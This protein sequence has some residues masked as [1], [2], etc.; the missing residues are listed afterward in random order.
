MKTSTKNVI[1]T[2]LFG[3][4]GLAGGSGINSAISNNANNINNNMITVN[5]DGEKIEVSTETIQ[6]TIDKNNSLENQIE[7]LINNN[8][9]LQQQVDTLTSDKDELKNENEKLSQ[10]VE[11]LKTENQTLTTQLNEPDSEELV[12]DNSSTK[13]GKAVPITSLTTFA[14]EDVQ[15][16]ASVIKDNTGVEHK[17]NVTRAWHSTF[18]INGKYKKLSGI[19]YQTFDNRSNQHDNLIEIFGDDKLVY[20]ATMN[21]GIMPISFDIDISGVTKLEIKYFNDYEY[22]AISNFNLY[23]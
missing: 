23:K 20:S 12:A 2:G 4:V 3:I 6:N 14:G 13:S 9:Q 5:I 18:L 17:N 21:S 19:F 22:T 10:E 11:D 8:T 16:N 15:S 7:E 1:I